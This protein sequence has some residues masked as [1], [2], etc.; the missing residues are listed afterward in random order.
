MYKI[1]SVEA[2]KLMKAG[3]MQDY[4]IPNDDKPNECCNLIEHLWGGEP[5][6]GTKLELLYY[7]YVIGY[8]KP[9]VTQVNAIKKAYDNGNYKSNAEVV[10]VWLLRHSEHQN[11]LSNGG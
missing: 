10:R 9:L 8:D 7:L 11:I 4:P 2:Y 3:G 6:V 1:K 5:I